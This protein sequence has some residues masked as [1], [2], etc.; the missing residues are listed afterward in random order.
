VIDLK[1]YRD[2]LRGIGATNRTK[3]IQSPLGRVRFAD[4]LSRG[5][6]AGLALVSF[7]VIRNPRVAIRS[8]SYS[9]SIP[10][11]RVHFLI[12]NN[13]QHVLQRVFT[14]P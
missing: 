13:P 1:Q 10:P 6:W 11:Y 9:H 7:P 14:L 2:R 5:A 12:P 3:V 4:R 8:R